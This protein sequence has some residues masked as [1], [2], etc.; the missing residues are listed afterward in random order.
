MTPTNIHASILKIYASLNDKVS[1]LKFSEPVAY[2]YNPLAYAWSGFVEYSRYVNGRKRVIFLGMNP[3]PWGMAQTGIPFG[4]I[5]AVKNFLCINNLHVTPP[6]NQHPLYPVNGL[7]CKRSEVSGRRLW[8]LFRERFITAENFFA[9]HVVLN[10]CPLLFLERSSGERVRNLTP[11]KLY[12]DEREELF[13]TCDES[14]REIVN[15]LKP[16]YVVGVGNF[17][18]IR[19]V[20]ALDGNNITITKILHPSPASPA[21]NRDWSGKVTEQLILSGIWNYNIS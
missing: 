14:L 8:K 1:T 16:A 11:D 9:E 21:S 3:G 4:E 15:I 18:A 2:V 17:A 20:K 19:A 12:P 13:A 10:Y 5:D 7:E 6:E